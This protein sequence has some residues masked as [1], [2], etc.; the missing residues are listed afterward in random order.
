MNEIVRRKGGIHKPSV[1]ALTVQ[2]VQ[3]GLSQLRVSAEAA[4]VDLRTSSPRDEQHRTLVGMP[5]DHQ[6]ENADLAIYVAEAWLKGERETVIQNGQRPV[7]VEA[8]L[9]RVKWPGRLDSQTVSHVYWS[10]DGAHTGESITIKAAAR[11]FA[12][13]LSRTPYAKTRADL[14]PYREQQ[15]R[16]SSHSA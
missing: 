2:Q 5:G 7:F 15:T 13:G 16:P 3:E 6:L 8:G 12:E 11:W 9:R 1:T 10:I 14:Q 4:D